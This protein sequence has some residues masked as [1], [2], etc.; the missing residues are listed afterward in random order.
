MWRLIKE[1]LQ[2]LKAEKK[3]WLLPI[4][5]ML[6]LLG[7]VILFSSSPALAPFMYPFM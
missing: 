2:F 4:I 5:I 3:W 1:F 6:I 7:L